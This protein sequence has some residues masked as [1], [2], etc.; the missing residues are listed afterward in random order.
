MKTYRM[1]AA[2]LA[3][4]ML[5]GV[6]A[7]CSKNSDNTTDPANPGSSTGTKT[8]TND[9]KAASTSKYTYQAEF[10][11]IPDNIQYVNTSTISGS[12]LYFTGSII[13]G[14][15]TFTDEN[16]EEIEYD[17]YRSALFRM[18][19]ETG[20]C[21][22]LTE[23]QLPEVPEGWMGSTDLNTIQTG[24]DGTLWAIYGSYTYRYNPPADLAADDSMYN[25][26]EQGENKTGLLHLDADGKELKRIEF[27]QTDENGNSFYV[28]NFFVD[29]SGNVYLSDWQNVYI[30][31]QDGNKK[32]TVDL[33]E[34]GGELCELKAGVVGVCYYKND[35]AKPEESGRVFQEIDP[36]TGKLTG[37]TVKL[38]DS[39]YNFFPG[40][41]VY[42]IYYDYNGNIYGYKF[43]TDTKDK[44]I[45]WI[46]CDINSN[47]LNSYSILPD[48][49]VIA[50]E[51][52]YDDG[53]GKNTMQ[54]IVMTRVDAA[55]V[56]N[57][58]VLT[59]ACMYLDWNMRDAIVK[60][61]RASNTHRI[62][63]RDYSEYNTDD[64][65]TAGIQK[66][67]TEMLSGKLPDM[68][69]INT[70]S[71]PIEQYAA[72]GFLTDLYELIDADADL[73]REDF[74]QPVLKALESA[75]G[76]L[77]QLPQ[78]FAVDTAIALDKVV[79]EY[80]TWNLAAV[81]DAMT[82]LQDGATVFDV[83]RTKSD[84]LSTCISRNIDAFVDWENGAA[85][86]DSDEFKALLEFANSFPD[87]YDWE[88][89]DEEDQDSAQN[90][91]NA[92][93][94]LMSSFYVSSL[95]D[96]LYQLTGYNGKVK[97]VGYPSED[98]TSNHAFQIDGA[99]AISSTCADKTA[100]W[101]FMKQF[102]NEE[103]QSSYN[104]WSFPINQAAFDAKLKE[105]MTEEY[106][107][108]DNG[109]VMKDDNG[110]PIR[111]PKVTYYTDGNGTMTGY[112][113]GNG[114]VAVMQ[115]SA[116][117][118]V[119]MGENGEVNVYAMTQ[120]QADEIL[121]LINATTAVYGYD[122]SIMGIITDEAAPYF[123]GEKSLDD[124][125]NM[126][127]SRVNLYVAEQS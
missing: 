37:D 71:M 120:E 111:I 94:Q 82:K 102:L 62:V 40:D 47:N 30:Y 53:M 66:L 113:T 31:D 81:K 65:Y 46:E 17:N 50:F 54:L 121:G 108:D 13:D 88:N 7:G 25:Y 34:N 106:Q 63:V 58:T 64:D 76:K 39:A 116:D 48:G 93:K 4:V 87:T 23:F 115:A 75:D 68:I 91:M 124:T 45:D 24:A 2:L 5:L 27:N 42:D 59:F 85:H 51:N 119:E 44:V 122:E 109:N 43:D 60:F 77:Y 15:K 101:N 96:I 125:V 52:S 92:G 97:F 100:A 67:N 57:K 19:V 18:D 55:S 69:D 21:T 61:N 28:S 38:P 84:I 32:T 112:S 26:Y 83:Y 3:I 79:G 99:I 74:V 114:G 29:N 8:E 72:K 49:R 126:I 90:R 80:D 9:E 98:G 107:T 12:N 6:F 14:K 78:T 123:A 118:S 22:E 105:M 86:F 16:G 70:Y 11:P 56:V 20:D 117:G 1:I 33:G 103:Y 104:I 36:A 41:D 95:E 89:A 35:E 73:S 10:L 110:N 127:Q